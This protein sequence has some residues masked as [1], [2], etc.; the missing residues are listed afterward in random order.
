MRK[1]GK[2]ELVYKPCKE[3]RK[4]MPELGESIEV[5]THVSVDNTFKQ[6]NTKLGGQLKDLYPGDYQL[7][8][9]FDR[10]FWLRHLKSPANVAFKALEAP[11]THECL[12]PFGNPADLSFAS[13]Y[14]D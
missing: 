7:L 12:C 10:A 4:V 6:I 3:L 2:C 13:F 9:A 5:K 1:Y 8:K 11:E 14:N